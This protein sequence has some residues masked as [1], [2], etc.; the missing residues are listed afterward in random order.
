MESPFMGSGQISKQEVDV[1]GIKGGVS[2]EGNDEIK[3]PANFEDLLGY[4]RLKLKHRTEFSY[5]ADDIRKLEELKDSHTKLE[6]AI[7]PSLDVYASNYPEYKKP[8]EE[9]NK[10]GWSDWKNGEKHVSDLVDKLKKMLEE[11]KVSTPEE[12]VTRRLEDFG[13]IEDK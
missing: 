6:F 13:K 10:K 9:I 11:A 4:Y 12:V 7:G 5:V 8:V 3:R 1:Q 2:N